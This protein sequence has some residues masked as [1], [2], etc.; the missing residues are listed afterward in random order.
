MTTPFWCIFIAMIIPYILAGMGGYFRLKHFDSYDNNNPRTQAAQLEGAG[1]R[2]IAAQS[3]AWEALAV[4]APV[5]IIAHI[6]GADP[7]KTALASII[8]IIARIL[9]PIVYILGIGAL[10]SLVFTIG[11]ICCIYIFFLGV[12]AP[13]HTTQAKPALTSPANP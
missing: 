4:F 11:V 1:A 8:F 2:C 5:V 9:H 3:N 13:D 6:L 12:N 7:G 10:R